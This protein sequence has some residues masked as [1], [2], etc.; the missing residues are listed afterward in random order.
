MKLYLREN[1]SIKKWHILQYLWYI[2]IRKK[3]HQ[4]ITNQ[5]KTNKNCNKYTFKYKVVYILQNII[6]NTNVPLSAYWA[7]VYFKL[8]KLMLKYTDMFYQE[9]TTVSEWRIFDV[10]D[11]ITAA[12]SYRQ[13]SWT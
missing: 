7:C 8:E 13:S 5:H 1:L 11:Y 4:F 6:T 2:L 12:T 3:N 10:A 9:F